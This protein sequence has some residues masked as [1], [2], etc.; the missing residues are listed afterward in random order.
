M[1]M[2]QVPRDPFARPGEFMMALKEYQVRFVITAREDMADVSREHTTHGD[3][4]GNS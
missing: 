4:R 1:L 2:G 3:P